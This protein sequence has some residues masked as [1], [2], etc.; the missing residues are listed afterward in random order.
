MA[1]DEPRGD[2]GSLGQERRLAAEAGVRDRDELR[3]AARGD[4]R[5]H[6]R[7]P[8][9]QERLGDATHEPFAQPEE[10][11]IAV[12]VSR[13]ADERAAVVVAIAVVHAIESG[14]DRVLDRPR[15]QDQHHRRQ[16]RDDRIGVVVGGPVLNQLPAILRTIV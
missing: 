6:Q 5:Q 16:K 3:V 10:I 15:Q 12:E 9:D 14:L 11:Q 13:E 7:H 1:G 8:V 4:G 2:L